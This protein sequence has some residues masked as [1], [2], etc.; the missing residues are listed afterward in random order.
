[1]NFDDLT[2]NYMNI[3]YNS[4][5]Y[6]NFNHKN[7]FRNVDIDNF[8]KKYNINIS[9]CNDLIKNHNKNFKAQMKLLHF[10]IQISTPLNKKKIYSDNYDFFNIQPELINIDSMR[11]LCRRNDLP[12]H[13]GSY[14]DYPHFTL[15]ITANNISNNYHLYL[16]GAL[17]INKYKFYSISI[18]ID[19]FDSHINSIK[20]KPKN[21]KKLSAS[22]KPFIPK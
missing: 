3:M 7:F 10:V 18:P 20:N 22:A 17:S 6:S 9:S 13:S 15:E 14:G 11:L 16:N 12:I 4:P 8:L 5:Y 19:L 21:N 2:N 1:M